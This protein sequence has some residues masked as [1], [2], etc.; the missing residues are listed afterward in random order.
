M[1]GNRIQQKM[2]VVSEGRGVQGLG[3]GGQNGRR[4]NGDI[5]NK[6]QQQ[7]K[8]NLKSKH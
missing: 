2:P 3:R 4:G 7:Q 8:I 5:C 6:S 1:E